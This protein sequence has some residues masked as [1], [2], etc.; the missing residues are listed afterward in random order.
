MYSSKKKESKA[1]IFATSCSSFRLN[2]FWNNR[3]ASRR[4]CSNFPLID[5]HKLSTVGSAAAGRERGWHQQFHHQRRVGSVRWVF[6]CLVGYRAR[7]DSSTKA[8]RRLAILKS[9]GRMIN[10]LANRKRYR[11]R[12]CHRENCLHLG[13][14]RQ[15]CFSLPKFEL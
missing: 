1:A 14:A 11:F 4:D 13:Q 5:R 9:R 2:R 7:P 8:S 15:Q 12:L 10:R 6:I 3:L